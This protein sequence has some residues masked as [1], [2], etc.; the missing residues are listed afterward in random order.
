MAYLNDA[1]RTVL[2]NTSLHIVVTMHRDPDADALGSSMGWAYFLKKLGHE[3]TV[4][5]PTDLPDN[6]KWLDKAS[7]VL[8]FEDRSNGRAASIKAFDEAD[9][10]CCLD[11]SAMSRLKEAGVFVR[12]SQAPILMIDHHLDPEPFATYMVSDVTAAATAQIIYQLIR[13]YDESLMDLS[14]AESLYAGIMTDTGSFRHNNTTREVHLAVAD[15][16]KYGVEVDKVHRLIFDNNPMSR[17]RMLGHSLSTIQ[18]LP[19][20]RTS[21]MVLT[22]KMLEEYQSNIGDTDG[23]VNYGLQIEDVVMTVLFIERNNEIKISFRSVAGFSVRELAH[24]H[25]EGGGHKN[26]S[27]GRSNLSLSATIEK[28]LGIL[29]HY[30]EQLLAVKK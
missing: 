12:R 30:Q 22:S 10:I 20:L 16:I 29:P 3:V 26:A 6:L 21:Y 4:I 19:E 18:L 11:F 23:I 13:E 14:I 2:Q 1:L 24:E 8:N 5:S 27:G 7:E 28:F 25:F 9:L 17:L 15:L